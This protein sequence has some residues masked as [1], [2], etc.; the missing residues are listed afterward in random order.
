M[1]LLIW[2]G[3]FTPKCSNWYLCHKV[4]KDKCVSHFVSNSVRIR[5]FSFAQTLKDS[6]WVFTWCNVWNEQNSVW[7]LSYLLQQTCTKSAKISKPLSDE[8]DSSVMLGN[9]GFNARWQVQGHPTETW[10]DWDLE[11]L[12]AKLTHLS[13]FSGHSRSSCGAAGCIILNPVLLRCILTRWSL[14]WF[15]P[16]CGCN[17]LADWCIIPKFKEQGGHFCGLKCYPCS[18]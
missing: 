3:T 13:Q 7:Y 9:P 11:N 12:E 1:R 6:F 17:A 5:I 14:L 8:A 4:C 15:S 18:N 2:S 16:V 10:S